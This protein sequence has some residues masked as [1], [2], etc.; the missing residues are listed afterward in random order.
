MLEKTTERHAH[1]FEMINLTSEDRK[2]IGL[3]TFADSPAA[4]HSSGALGK[5]HHWFEKNENFDLAALQNRVHKLE[6]AHR[7][8]PSPDHPSN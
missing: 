2:A 7:D 4:I 5:M 6:T 8:A 3:P 1:A